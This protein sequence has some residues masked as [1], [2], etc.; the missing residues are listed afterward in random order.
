[1][2]EQSNPAGDDVLFLA[3]HVLQTE[4]NPSDPESPAKMQEAVFAL[5]A[6]MNSRHAFDHQ[7]DHERAEMLASIR[8]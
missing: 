1:M 3:Q 6:A 4:I 2:T 8:R 5:L 7:R